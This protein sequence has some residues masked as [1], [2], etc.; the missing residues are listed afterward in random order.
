MQIESP[1]LKLSFAL[2]FLAACGSSSSKGNDAGD[3]TGGAGGTG[4]STSGGTGGATVEFTVVQPCA[5]AADYVEGKTVTFP[6]ADTSYAPKCLKVAPG[7]TVT[8]MTSEGT[9]AMHPLEAARRR[10]DTTNNP[11]TTTMGAMTSRE[12]TFTF[13]GF[14]G[15]YCGMHGDDS[16]GAAEAGVIWVH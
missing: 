13:S 7:D 6:N 10:G 4:G 3:G 5:T 11:I 2:L 14:Y 9:F 1:N 16:D 8:F 15:Y 12:F